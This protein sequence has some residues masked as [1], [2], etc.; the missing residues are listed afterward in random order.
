[1]TF[2]R[3]IPGEKDPELEAQLQGLDEAYKTHDRAKLRQLFADL[4]DA[5]K[6]YA[7]QAHPEY[8]GEMRIRGL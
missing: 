6:E 7:R 4:G 1:M 8:L 2:R 5:L 3:P